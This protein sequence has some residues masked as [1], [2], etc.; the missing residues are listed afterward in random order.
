MSHG[1]REWISWHF[2]SDISRNM[3]SKGSRLVRGAFLM[4]DTIGG[5]GGGAE[6]REFESR[7]IPYFPSVTDW[8]IDILF[9]HDIEE[10]QSLLIITW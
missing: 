6:Y 8:L 3:E 5:G 2:I 1:G 9:L 10:L 7:L 4:V